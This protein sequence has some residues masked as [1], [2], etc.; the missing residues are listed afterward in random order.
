MAWR[1]QCGKQ[2]AVLPP[3]CCLPSGR[4]GAGPTSPCASFEAPAADAAGPL[5]EEEEA[6]VLLPAFPAACRRAAGKLSF[7]VLHGMYPAM[8]EGA[9]LCMGAQAA[10]AALSCRRNKQRESANCKFVSGGSKWVQ[11]E[12]R[13]G[14]MTTGRSQC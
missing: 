8:R 10:G 11:L 2:A 14:D 3:L 5:E 6:A 9:L 12:V 13:R 4:K 7:S 1:W